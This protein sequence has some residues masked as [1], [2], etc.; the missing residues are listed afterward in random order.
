VVT[1]QW[2]GRRLASLGV[3]TAVISAIIW[4]ACGGGGEAAAVNCRELEDKSYLFDVYVVIDLQERDG[5][6]TDDDP[7]GP[8]QFLLDQRIEGAFDRGRFD[9]EITNPESFPAGEGYQVILID[10]D[11]WLSLDQTRWSFNQLA[12]GRPHPVQYTPAMIC[13]GILDLDLDELP[14]ETV[15]ED[16]GSFTR[17]EL[18]S[19]PSDLARALWDP[20]SDMGRIVD[21]FTGEIWIADDS[22][23]PKRVDLNGLGHYQSGRPLSVTV[24]MEIKEL[25]SADISIEPPPG[26]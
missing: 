18:D 12:P 21:L 6:P 2:R 4:V 15:M 5:E 25:N 16:E 14:S 20:L 10:D 17:Y 22:G 1:R 26:F 7:Y 8:E 11:Y 23:I 19:V 9:V 3:A 24:S 13:Q